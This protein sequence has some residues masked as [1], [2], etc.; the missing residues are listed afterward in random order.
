[1]TNS[2]MTSVTNI[3]GTSLNNEVQ[4]IV[5]TK[6]ENNQA[7]P[8]EQVQEAK[9]AIVSGFTTMFG[10]CTITTGSGTWLANNQLEEEE[11]F[12]LSSNFSDTLFNTSTMKE[13][14]QLAE[15]LKEELKQDMVSVKVNSELFFI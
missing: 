13:I 9:K 2:T 4:I 15:N 1:M 11:N 5:C 7:L 3:L 12:I 14:K 8:V 6:D 10:G